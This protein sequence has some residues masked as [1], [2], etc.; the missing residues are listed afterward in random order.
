M[1][2]HFII[3][4][5]RPKTFAAAI[6]SVSDFLDETI[7]LDNRSEFDRDVPS[8]QE[9]TDYE[10][11]V[12]KVEVALGISQAITLCMYHAREMG[13]PWFSYMHD[14]CVVIDEGLERMRTF[15][16]GAFTS[17]NVAMVLTKSHNEVERGGNHI[18]PS[19]VMCCFDVAA[20]LHV[21]GY[22]WISFPDYHGDL[23]LYSRLA[24]AGYK[25]IQSGVTV[26]HRD[27]DGA[28]HRASAHRMRAHE[29]YDEAG[30][31]LWFRLAAE[32]GHG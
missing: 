23:D 25:T 2:P 29:A 18:G 19:D 17:P 13:A 24:L 4:T 32:R 26:E 28:T 27:I 15:A 22:D 30:R 12:R 3:Y 10:I 11:T 20:C 7:V 1:I 9:A 31:Q 6:E 5:S 16:E 14:D 8:P 21:G